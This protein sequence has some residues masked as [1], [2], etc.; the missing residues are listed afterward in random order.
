MATVVHFVPQ[1]CPV[2]TAG[3]AS[4]SVQL[5]VVMSPTQF[6]A[7]PSS[8]RP[9]SPTTPIPTTYS[10]ARTI[11]S[12]P[13][14]TMTGLLGAQQQWPIQ[15]AVTA[16]SSTVGGSRNLLAAGNLVSERSTTEEQLLASGNLI[17]D[18]ATEAALIQQLAAI[19]GA[20]TPAELM[21][22]A[23][24]AT[25]RPKSLTGP[26]LSISSVPA[27]CLGHASGRTPR[28]SFSTA[29]LPLASRKTFNTRTLPGQFS[30]MQE[31]P[32]TARPASS[33]VPIYGQQTM[34]L[35]GNQQIIGAAGPEEVALPDDATTCVDSDRGT[36]MQEVGE[37]SLTTS[38]TTAC[39]VLVNDAVQADYP[40]A[41]KNVSAPKTGIAARIARAGFRVP[42]M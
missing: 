10:G 30:G 17:R 22:R 16:S 28:R 23:D 14:H 27:K 29:K 11:A 19:P 32:A 36:T 3:Q 18:E 1:P 12:P 20:L 7:V 5:P 34:A 13:R 4:L 37:P 33:L 35:G 38:T 40:E 15:T 8:A 21:A 9:I 24:Q 26:L 25:P 39:E 42:G 2:V 31:Q 41:E 6:H